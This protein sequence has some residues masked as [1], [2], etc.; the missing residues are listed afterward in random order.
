MKSYALALLAASA[1]A[2]TW[3][4]DSEILG[5]VFWGI[6]EKES[7]SLFEVCAQD[8]DIFATQILHSF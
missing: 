8:A 7:W 5:G 3:E 4:Q 1:A 6:M 2:T